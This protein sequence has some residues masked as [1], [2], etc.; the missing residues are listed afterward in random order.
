MTCYI[1]PNFYS[2]SRLTSACF[3]AALAG[4]VIVAPLSPATLLGLR[5]LLPSVTYPLLRPSLCFLNRYLSWLAS[6][7]CPHP[8][9]ELKQYAAIASVR[10][11]VCNCPLTT[12]NAVGKCS[13]PTALE[14][15]PRPGGENPK[16]ANR[17]RVTAP[18]S[19]LGGYVTA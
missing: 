4:I 11:G 8:R 3:A 17:L 19:Q 6:P 13:S 12:S 15:P 5:R 18:T 14:G 2:S 9:T 16:K 10:S 7:I 1:T